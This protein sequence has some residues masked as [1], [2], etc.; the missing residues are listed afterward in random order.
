MKRKKL[1]TYC[2]A[3]CLG[4]E[5]GLVC[6]LETSRD[7]I[8]PHYFNK[9]FAK[10]L[11]SQWS[12]CFRRTRLQHQPVCCLSLQLTL[13]TD[14]N[15]KPSNQNTHKESF[16]L[17]TFCC[18]LDVLCGRHSNFNKH[19]SNVPFTADCAKAIIEIIIITRVNCPSIAPAVLL[20]VW[21]EFFD[22]S[23]LVLSSSRVT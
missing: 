5:T 19:F 15:P 17:D 10:S 22:F 13:Q 14:S 6:T 4:A 18:S 12:T 1:S 7:C 11:V 20:L 9:P 21:F 8:I 16:T 23:C 2:R 3:V